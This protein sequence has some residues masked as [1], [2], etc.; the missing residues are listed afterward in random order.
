MPRTWFLQRSSI[1]ARIIALVAGYVL[2][3]GAVYAGFGLFLV[4]RD[5]ARANDRLEQT[6]QLVAAQIDAYVES[7]RQRLATVTRLPGMTYGL[8]TIEDNSGDG[9]IPPWTT[10]HYLFFK[11][12]TFTGGV[13]LLDR[14]GK[15]LWTEPPGQTWMGKTLNEHPSVA[16]MYE[17]KRGLISDGLDADVLLDRPHVVMTMPV[18]NPAGDIDGALIGVIDLAAPEF[19]KCLGAV[20]TTD[21]R[22]VEVVDQNDR[23]IAGSDPSRLFQTARLAPPGSGEWILAVVALPHAPWRVVA[24]QSRALALAEV[25][26]FQRLLLTIGFGLVALAVAVGAPLIARFARSIGTLTTAAETIGRG[27]LSRPVDVGRQRDELATLARSFEQMR[28]ELGRSRAALEG[29]LE[30][31]EELIQVKEIFLANI[32]HELRTPLNAIIGYADML[33]EQ[34]LEPEGRDFLASIRTHS[35]HLFELLSD[36]LTLSGVNLGKLP[37][38][39]CPVHIPTF[40]TRL[41]PLID[42]LRTGK[43]IEVKWDC[44]PSL[45][46]VETDPLR[47]E[48]ILTNLLTNALKFTAHGQV[49]IRVRHEQQ[50][51]RVVFE[52][53]DTGIGIPEHEVAHIFDEFR[54]V[55]GSP[56]RAHGGVGLGLALVKKLTELLH[57]DVTVRTCVGKGSTFAVILPRRF[58]VPPPNLGAA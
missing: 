27:D 42:S 38:E 22:F 31:R 8:G 4:G 33:A 44:P 9:R 30:E 53:S 56:T 15:A 20:S 54:Q 46:S 29:R 45:P 34:S 11:S 14:T 43:P 12:P 51:D 36:L 6:A 58:D 25:W 49:A 57:G 18:Q 3:L 52:V 55:G 21:G 1:T 50:T 10:L 5:T 40:I 2:A 37:V 39:I 19:T 47:L 23:V 24:G 35:L 32:S 16:S 48:Q 26:Q 13:C 17:R 7:G 41:E 28:I